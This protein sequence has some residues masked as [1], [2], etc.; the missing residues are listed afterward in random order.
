MLQNENGPTLDDVLNE[1]VAEQESPT[2]EALEIWVDRY[3]QFRQELVE[4][5]AA[6]AELTILPKSAE[7]TAEQEKRI[8][9]RAMSHIHPIFKAILESF[10][11]PEPWMCG[12]CKADECENCTRENF[13]TSEVCCC[14]EQ[15][16]IR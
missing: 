11:P 15:G 16:H 6:W 12:P 1:F 2:G 5:A 8:A 3:P 13:D 7:L 10:A 9:D 14:H 4:F